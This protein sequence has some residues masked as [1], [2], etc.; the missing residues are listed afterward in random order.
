[1]NPI[2]H[3]FIA[4]IQKE[5]Q[6]SFEFEEFP[7]LQAYYSRRIS[8]GKKPK[9]LILT[10]IY[11]TPSKLNEEFYNYDTQTIPSEQ[12]FTEYKK[13]VY[14]DDSNIR[15]NYSPSNNNRI[16]I[17]RTINGKNFIDKN[18]LYSNEKFLENFGYYERNN[19]K[20]KINPKYESLTKVVGY[21]NIIPFEKYKNNMALNTIDNINDDFNKK[22]YY[23]KKKEDYI[24]NNYMKKKEINIIQKKEFKKPIT[25]INLN[26]KFEVKKNQVTKK[27]IK[28]DNYR[29][30]Q[31]SENKNQK[32]NNKNKI[33]QVTKKE[34]KEPKIIKRRESIKKEFKPKSG[35]Y[36]YKDNIENDITNS[37]KN[38]N[39]NNQDKN[40]KR[41][42]VVESSKSKNKKVTV[43]NKQINKIITNKVNINAKNNNY[44]KRQN[45]NRKIL[46]KKSEK[47]S[48]EKFD[49]NKYLKGNKSDIGK[50][51]NFE[52]INKRYQIKTENENRC[53][54]PRLKT[55]NFGDN[56]RYYERKYL[57]SPENDY[58]TIHQRRDERVIYG[59]EAENRRMK[60]YGIFPYKIGKNLNNY[61]IRYNSLDEDNYLYNDENEE[62]Y[63]Q[64][65][66]YY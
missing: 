1:M 5:Q 10:E 14:L 50:K 30:K 56:Y 27:N 6:K 2:S 63:K 42:N 29:I 52:E 39:E 26:K 45:D 12:Y 4:G 53:L 32:K 59:E 37:R 8:S 58:Y 18:Y 41:I 15:N 54:S 46:I 13:N 65:G 33:I 49:K 47:K 9:K 55:I 61:K 66:F 7:D 28:I 38:Y 60:K 64:E 24:K 62:I 40:I 11:D 31:K 3:N 35:R 21:S 22:N 51:I 43:K 20:E 17:L 36:S 48:Y 23:L 44:L 16:N 57:Q 34:I 25:K 19:I